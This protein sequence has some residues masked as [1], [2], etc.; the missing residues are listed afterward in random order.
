MSKTP[1]SAS[2]PAAVTWVMPWS[3]AAG[4]RCV[5]TSPFVVAPQMKKLPASSQKVGERQASRSPFTAA[6]KGLLGRSGT[7]TSTA[8]PSG[9]RPICAG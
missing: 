8:E 7:G 6:R 4:M 2:R 1:M 5:E 3:W 9:R